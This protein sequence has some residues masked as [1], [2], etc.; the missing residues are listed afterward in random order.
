MRERLFWLLRL[1]SP[2]L[3]PDAFALMLCAFA[4]LAFGINY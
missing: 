3:R 4:L 1:Y 2:L